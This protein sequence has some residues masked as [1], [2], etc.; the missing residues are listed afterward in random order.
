MNWQND[1]IGQM[2]SAGW[3]PI[4]KVPA[5]KTEKD[6]KQNVST[7]ESVKQWRHSSQLINVLTFWPLRVSDTARVSGSNLI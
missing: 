5:K 1:Q 6:G 3:L 7:D 4:E 2:K